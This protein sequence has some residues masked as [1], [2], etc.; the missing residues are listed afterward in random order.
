M[1]IAE[2][3]LPAIGTT[4][5]T[6]KSLYD[7][8]IHGEIMRGIWMRD[9]VA[10]SI[11]MSGG[12]ED[13]E[14]HG[15]TIVYTGDGGRD[16]DSRKQVADQELTARN[17]GLAAAMDCGAPIRVTRG[18]KLKS[19]FAPAAGYRY[20]GLY[21]VEDRDLRRGR[22]GFLV[23]VFSLVKVVDQELAASSTTVQLPGGTMTPQRRSSRVERVIRS[24]ALSDAIKK[25]YDYRCQVC[26]I[27]L[28]KVTGGYA[29]GAHIRPVGQLH[30]GPDIPSNLLCL[31]P[32]HHVL[33][34]DGAIWIDDNL[35]VFQRGKGPIGPLNVNEA[36]KIDLE[37]LRYHRLHRDAV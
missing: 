4:Y 30:K 27:R 12:Y 6:R 31:C 16:I 35:T 33:F 11:V 32:N 15:G 1:N 19:P 23:W 17:R 29:E 13:D 34:D 36:H 22:S 18:S 3:Q 5:P 24:S 26:D 28:E 37:Q 14:D 2:S 9:G 25:L 7:A 10:V 8:G 21:R 20:D